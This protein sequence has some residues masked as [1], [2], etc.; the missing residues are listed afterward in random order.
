M[1][2]YSFRLVF[3][4]LVFLIQFGNAQQR[5]VSESELNALLDTPMESVYL[6][7]N[8][9]TFFP[10]ETLYYS[11]Y[12]IN[13]QTYRQSNISKIVYVQL[14]NEFGEVLEAQRVRL[15]QGRGQGDFFFNTKYRSGAYKI[16]AFTNWMKNAGVKQQFQANLTVVNPYQASP[17]NMLSQNEPGLKLKNQNGISETVDSEPSIGLQMQTSCKPCKTESEIELTLKN[18]K[19]TLAAGEYSLSVSLV[20]EIPELPLVSAIDFGESYSAKSRYFSGKV[21][22]TLWIPE[23]R[24][25][26]ISGRLLSA[27]DGAS[28]QNTPIVISLPGDNFQLLT[29]NTNSEGQ[30]TV[31]LKAPFEGS[32]AYFAVDDE[33]YQDTIIEFE[34]LADWNADLGQFENI[35]LDET[36]SDAIRKR[37]VH[38]QIENGFFEAKPDTVLTVYS[39]ESYFGNYPKVYNLDDFTR[40]ATFREIL[41]EIIQDVWVKTGVNKKETLWVRAPLQ[42]GREVYTEYPPI[43]TVDGVWIGNHASILDLNANQIRYVRVVQEAINWGGRKYQG[44]V[45]LETRDGNYSSGRPFNFI[46]AEPVKRYFQQSRSDKNS[47]IPD[48]RHQLYWNPRITLLDINYNISFSTS[49]VPGLYCAQLEGFTTYGKPL[50]LRYYFD[51][52]N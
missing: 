6:H 32:T 49:Q 28:I 11:V 24:E 45:A 2:D 48:F 35:G 18:L 3:G 29:A 19:G 8:R 38:N 10:G 44:M 51:V 27:K 1:K 46:P 7:I 22:D 31:Y 17:L 50:S 43:V 52:V 23:Q 33:F 34:N 40:F 13:M 12:A 4:F 5:I 41:V 47:H 15:Q 14:I 36:M 21:F 16:I 39:E 42:E 20:E 26:I 30:F 37:S 25:A 9:T